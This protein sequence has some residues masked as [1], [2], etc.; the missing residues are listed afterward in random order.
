[1]IEWPLVVVAGLLGSSHCLGMCGPLA[2]AVGAGTRDV[3]ANLVRQ[4]TYSAGR[5]ATYAALGR[6]EDAEWQAE[7]ILSLRPEFSVAAES[8]DKPFQRARDRELYLGGLLKAGL[9]E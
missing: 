6:Q 3:R 2:L 5:I 7:E 8:R 1:M 4:L 9:P